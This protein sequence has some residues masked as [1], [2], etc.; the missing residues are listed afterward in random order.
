[1]RSA[2]LMDL[3]A[4]LPRPAERLDTRYQ[5]IKRLLACQRA[6]NAPQFGACKIPHLAGPAIS[7]ERDG[8][9]HSWVVGRAAEGA[10]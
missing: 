7:R 4:C 9:L 3:A 5:W 2:N 6:L 1:V 8:Q 10:A